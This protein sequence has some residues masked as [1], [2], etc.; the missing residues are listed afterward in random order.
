L[1]IKALTSTEPRFV[2]KEA[3]DPLLRE[4]HWEY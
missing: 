2:P 1:T 3:I 4:P